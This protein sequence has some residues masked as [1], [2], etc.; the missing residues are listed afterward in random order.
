LG[1]FDVQLEE[2]E[3]ILPKKPKKLLIHEL[4]DA[5]NHLPHSTKEKTDQN[6]KERNETPTELVQNNITSDEDVE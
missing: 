4:E 3:L 5:D 6:K 1:V 2:N